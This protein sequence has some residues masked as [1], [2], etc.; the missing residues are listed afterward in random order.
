M[1]YIYK[2]CENQPLSQSTHLMF[3]LHR[4]G[5]FIFPPV[6]QLLIDTYGWRGCTV[7]LAGVFLNI[8]VCGALMRD[9][10]WTS[11]RAKQKRKLDQEKKRKT[12]MDSFSITTSTNNG[13]ATDGSEKGCNIDIN[14]V[15]TIAEEDPHLFSSLINL[16]TFADKGEKVSLLYL[17]LFYFDDELF[18]F[19]LQ[20]IRYPLEFLNSCP[21]T[22]IFTMFFCTI[23]RIC[24]AREA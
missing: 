9:L 12:S 10:K 16:P 8:C 18:F 19:S 5:T 17:F 11:F 20:S 3:F 6:I 13:I 2:F 1:Y 22:V 23:I 7:I 4:I 21:R 15:E 24:L 14:V